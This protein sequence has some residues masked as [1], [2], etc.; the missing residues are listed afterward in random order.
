[1]LSMMSDAAYDI[2]SISCVCIRV[3]EKQNFIT[4]FFIVSL[5]ITE[6]F[7]LWPCDRGLGL[8]LGLERYGLLNITGI[9]KA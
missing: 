8:G 5:C 7:R 9:N 4:L 1:M 6:W 3:L 2:N